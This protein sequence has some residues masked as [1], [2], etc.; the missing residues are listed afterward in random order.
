[1][2][3][4]AFQS[5]ASLVGYGVGNQNPCRSHARVPASRLPRPATPDTTWSNKICVQL[6][7]YN[8]VQP[9]RPALASVGPCWRE[10]L[11]ASGS[12]RGRGALTTALT[13][14]V[15][16][17][18]R[19][20]QIWACSG[21]CWLRCGCATEFALVRHSSRRWQ[22]SGAA[23]GAE[24]GAERAGGD[25]A[26]VRR[27]VGSAWAYGSVVHPC[28]CPALAKLSPWPLSSSECRKSDSH[29]FST[30]RLHRACPA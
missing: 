26:G 16:R 30:Q 2:L 3:Q 10:V 12:T 8:V 18:I 14:P 23:G 4:F 22:G 9:L 25:V 6:Y 15:R 28:K 1:M 17:G 7:A 29:P 20:P 27:G 19:Q 11:R 5:T 24:G 13:V 21:C